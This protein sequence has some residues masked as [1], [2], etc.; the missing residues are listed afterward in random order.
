MGRF[1]LEMQEFQEQGLLKAQL[2]IKKG[3][4]ANSVPLPLFLS[5][6]HL[7]KNML[8]FS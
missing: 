6:I 8:V 3:Q 7:R 5:I 1:S 4:I 2:F